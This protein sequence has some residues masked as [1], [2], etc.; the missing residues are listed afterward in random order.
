MLIYKTS[1]L[2]S[3]NFFFYHLKSDF[4]FASRSLIAIDANQVVSLSS[5][6]NLSLI[7][8]W[9]NL[10]CSWNCCCCII[11]VYRKYLATFDTK[12][13]LE[14]IH[15]ILTRA[16]QAHM[17]LLF[18][19]TFLINCL[20]LIKGKMSLYLVTSL[21]DFLK[22]INYCVLITIELRKSRW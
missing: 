3:S 16:I 7:T 2:L 21:D 10:K 20:T 13:S 14:T 12:Y 15:V 11:V 6:T 1:R 17:L 4:Y 9:S 22:N 5:A 18:S 19:L 8:V